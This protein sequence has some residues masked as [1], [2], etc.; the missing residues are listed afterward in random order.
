MLRVSITLVVLLAAISCL[1]AQRGVV[2]DAG[3][4]QPLEGATIYAVNS[5]DG[6]ITDE[7]GRFSLELTQFPDT[8][9][10]SYLGYE[11][12]VIPIRRP[13]TYWEVRLESTSSLLPEIIVNS[14][15][16]PKQLTE[17]HKSISDFLVIGEQLLLLTYYDKRPH[18]RLSI[19]DQAG[20]ILQTQALAGR[21]PEQ[22]FQGCLGGLYLIYPTHLQ[23]LRI[24]ANHIQLADS[25]TIQAYR[26]TLR[27]CLYANDQYVFPGYYRHHQQVF[28]LF[29]A[30]RDGSASQL[31]E[32][33][34]NEKVLRHMEDEERFL[35]N[36]ARTI[37]ET[38]PQEGTRVRRM[39]ADERR[40][41]AQI[42]YR[43]VRAQVFPFGDLL[44]LFDYTNHRIRWLDTNGNTHRETP[45][46]FHRRNP[47]KV[48]VLRDKIYDRLYVLQADN[49][50]TYLY[51]IDPRTGQL[52]EAAAIPEIY[53]KKVQVRAGKLFYLHKG[54]TF[55]ERWQYLYRVDL[56]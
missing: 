40:F 4:Q 38:N 34:V 21:R 28:Q 37:V 54:V 20:N 17:Q 30:P 7:E 9:I 26:N 56:E 22:L 42:L 3:S 53:I 32:T 11:Q 5:E 33:I 47:Y 14:Y 25:I 35:A 39:Y 16:R 23:E 49:K 19:A 2:L 51:E 46:V 6:T 15:R 18:Y 8:L 52:S 31:L 44:L 27:P 13:D 1:N 29:A 43:P 48:E 41:A 12:E 50:Y 24:D 45:I 36:K 55:E 10:V